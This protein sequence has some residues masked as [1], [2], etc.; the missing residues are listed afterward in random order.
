M[1]KIIAVLE[2]FDIIMTEVQYLPPIE[3]FSKVMKFPKIM[4]ERYEHFVKSSYRNRCYLAGPNGALRLTVPLKK[5]KNQHTV[6][7][8]VQ[9]AYDF[10][11]QKIHWQS[12]CSVY[13]TSPYF[14]YYEDRFAPF[15]KKQ[16]KYLFDFN[17][18]LMQMIFKILELEKEIKFTDKY[19]KDYPQDVLDFRSCIHPKSE[20][21]IKDN[22]FNSPIYNQVFQDKVGFLS[23]MS[24]VDLIFCEGT[25]ASEIL[26]LAK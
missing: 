14:E 18:E 17:W 6:I 7:K 10:H 22:G 11:W 26:E 21:A 9:I 15:Y 5:G 1:P 24:I 3:Y 16:T 2:N 20:K 4:I 12:L 19:E 8:D 25:S 23:N 13:R